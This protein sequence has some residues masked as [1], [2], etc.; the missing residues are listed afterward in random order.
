MVHPVHSAAIDYISGRADSLAFLFAAAAWLSVLRA[1]TANSSWSKF[2]LYVL[3]AF[4]ALLALCSR[5]T[6]CIWL[7]IFL[8]HTLGF[9]KGVAK[10]SRIVTVICCLFVFGIYA[11]LHQL[12]GAR[13]QQ[14]AN[15][16]WPP[17]AR[18]HEECGPPT[19]SRM[20][21]VSAGRARSRPPARL[22]RC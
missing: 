11:E 12:P 9:A 13:Q 7:F 22:L 6:A 10:K 20:A 2:T 16:N 17:A 3:A 4:S 14:G 18:T 21:S 19:A 1:R 8:L 15:D 5:E